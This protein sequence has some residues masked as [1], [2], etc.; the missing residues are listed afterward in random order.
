M[1]RGTILQGSGEMGMMKR[2]RP[3]MA[4]RAFA[5][6][7]IVLAGLASWFTVIETGGSQGLR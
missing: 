7:T 5:G 2:K 6:L 1:E 3:T 4:L